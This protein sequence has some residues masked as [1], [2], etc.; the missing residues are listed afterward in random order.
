[1]YKWLTDVLVEVF[2][3][4]VAVLCKRVSVRSNWQVYIVD[5][6]DIGQHLTEVYRNKATDD[7][8]HRCSGACSIVKGCRSN[9]QE[10]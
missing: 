7:I 5:T 1:M 6:V 4:K 9:S 10:S 8:Y 2:Y 3:L